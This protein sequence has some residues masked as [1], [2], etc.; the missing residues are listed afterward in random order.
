MD[1]SNEMNMQYQMPLNCLPMPKL[2]TIYVKMQDFGELFA[3]M[4]G[5]EKGTIFPDLY[6][7]YL[8][9]FLPLYNNNQH[10]LM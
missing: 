9:P 8:N 5:L 3:P 1:Y 4:E 6:M 7:P 10:Y 2:E